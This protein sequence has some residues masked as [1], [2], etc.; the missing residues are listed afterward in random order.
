MAARIGSQL[1]QLNRLS[2]ASLLLHNT[3][4]PVT[5]GLQG[6]RRTLQA[7]IGAKSLG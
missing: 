2:S 1:D 6:W 4:L 7:C 3:M 5:E